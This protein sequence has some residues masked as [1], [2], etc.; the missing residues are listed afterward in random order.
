[1]AVR[2]QAGSDDA[3]EEH[4]IQALERE[5]DVLAAYTIAGE[6]SLLLK[7]VANRPWACTCGC[8]RSGPWAPRHH[9]TMMILNTYFEK[10]GPSPFS[11][12]IQ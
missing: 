3:L 4:F 9:R 1:V 5:P 12:E 7:I 10:T 11:E 2:Y 8:A 6:D